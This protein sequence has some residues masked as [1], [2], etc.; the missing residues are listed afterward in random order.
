MTATRPDC[1]EF[2][3][4]DAVRRPSHG[5]G[6]PALTSRDQADI[7]ADVLGRPIAFVDATPAE[8]HD[9]AVAGGTPREAADAMENLN[10]LFRR[11]GPGY[12]PTTSGP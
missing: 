10:E 6:R 1:A 3:A 5:Y 8:V 12:S 11:A 4:Q 9:A 7:L 2:P